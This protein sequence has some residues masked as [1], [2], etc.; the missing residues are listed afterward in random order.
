M[1]QFTEKTSD[2]IYFIARKKKGKKKEAKPGSSIKA[3]WLSQI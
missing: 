2:M 3:L 1:M